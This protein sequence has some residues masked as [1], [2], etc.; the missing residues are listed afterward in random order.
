MNKSFRQLVEETLIEQSLDEGIL[1]SFMT[2]SRSIGQMG[3]AGSKLNKLASSE[4][5]DRA[6]SHHSFGSGEHDVH[7]ADVILNHPKST[8]H[9]RLAVINKLGANHPSVIKSLETSPHSADI[10]KHM[11]GNH[12]G[13]PRD[14]TPRTLD[15]IARVHSDASVLHGVIHHPNTGT[16]TFER[17]AQYVKGGNKIS[18]T[19]G[20]AV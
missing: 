18:V 1:P 14:L 16:G 11:V 12:N 20:N 2:K 3:G 19:D 15:T 4:T 9:Q 10:A 8:G 5:M 17:V 6:V 7:N 13:K